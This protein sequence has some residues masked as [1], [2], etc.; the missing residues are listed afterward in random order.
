VGIIEHSLSGMDWI[1][2][3]FGMEYANQWANRNQSKGVSP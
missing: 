3:E 1:V 2:A